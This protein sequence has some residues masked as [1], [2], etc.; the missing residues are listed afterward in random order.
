MSY[1]RQNFKQ[2][3]NLFHG[4]HPNG[5]QE[6]KFN[7]PGKKNAID[8]EDLLKLADLFNDA[9]NND[10][11]RVVLIHGGSY[12]SSGNDL[13]IFMKKLES[14]SVE[15]VI[16]MAQE[17]AQVIIVKMLTALLDL[18]KPLVLMV[19]GAAIGVACTMSAYADFIYCTPEAIFKTPFL[20]SFQSPEGGSTFTFQQ[21]LSRRV[22]AQMIFADK[23]L[24]AK[25]ALKLGYITD[26][27]EAKDIQIENG[28]YFDIDK[29]PCI[30]Q[31]LKNDL[32]TTV[33]AKRLLNEGLN[34]KHL[35][36]TIEREGKSLAGIYADEEFLP[37]LFQYMSQNTSRKAKTQPQP[38]H[39][40]KL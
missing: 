22:A 32:K 7:N 15:E 40:A 19:S 10:Q 2:V 38:L 14:H 24:T 28:E 31:I 13:S 29:I 8:M 5:V 3:G 39:D 34:K 26:I 36:K 6:I 37:K 23:S 25:Q 11:V 18:E 20:Q 12:Y 16:K 21:Q 4:I 9:N 17:G 35:M 33:N 27:I 1:N 30:P